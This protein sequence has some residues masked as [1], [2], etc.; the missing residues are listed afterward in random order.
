MPLKLFGPCLNIVL[1]IKM[2]IFAKIILILLPLVFLF[3]FALFWYK[4][5]FSL[6][7]M[8]KSI[9]QKKEILP[10]STMFRLPH[11]E[12]LLVTDNHA[13]FILAGPYWT[14]FGGNY[15]FNL[16]ITPFCSGKVFSRIEAVKNKGAIILNQKDIVA[17][18]ESETQL[19]ELSFSA[20]TG[21]NYEFRLYSYGV[22]PFEIKK[23]WLNKD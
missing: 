19:E 11:Q 18:K 14:L 5:G 22:C 9:V 7:Q 3:C 8:E 6:W 4:P 2:K 12:Q 16:E 13:Q 10:L 23:G 20:R 1:K 15:V 21:A 17:I